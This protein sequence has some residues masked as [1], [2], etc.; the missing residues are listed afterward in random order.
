MTSYIE[1]Y[2]ER[3]QET[4][5][6]ILNESGASIRQ[7]A[8]A[9]ADTIQKGGMLL[10]FGSGHSAFIAKDMAY[11]AGGLAPVL[12]ID[13]VADGDAERLEG[14]A[15]YLLARYELRPGNVILIISN[16]GI[17]PVPIEMAQ[18]AKQVGLKTIAITSLAH[19]RSMTSR[20]S[21]GKKLYEIVDIVEHVFLRLYL[22]D[23]L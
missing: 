13:D 7:A 23:N 21:S 19:S 1:A 12:A 11:R 3:T 18:I 9:I 20:H 5:G 17:N 16:S 14:L 22:N 4:L 10:T 15:Q 6:R 2:F 8:E